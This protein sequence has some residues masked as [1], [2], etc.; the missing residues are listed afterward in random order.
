MAS[1]G[2]GMHNAVASVTVWLWHR[3]EQ[4]ARP[5]KRYRLDAPRSD[6]PDVDCNEVGEVV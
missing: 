1:R 2:V 5:P 3:R 4:G 6:F